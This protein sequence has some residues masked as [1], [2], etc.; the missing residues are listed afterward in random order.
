MTEKT[1]KVVFDATDGIIP[2][3]NRYGLTSEEASA[4]AEGYPVYKLTGEVLFSNINVNPKSI[5][6]HNKVNTQKKKLPLNHCVSVMLSEDS[7]FKKTDKEARDLL[8]QARVQSGEYEGLEEDE[9]PKYKTVLKTVTKKDVLD[10]KFKE[11]Q[12]GRAII[13]FAISSRPQN[14]K[15]EE[16]VVDEQ[17][18][19][20]YDRKTAL[21]FRLQDLLTGEEINPVIFKTNKSGEREYT[22]ENPQTKTKDPLKV[23]SGDLVNVY[24]RPYESQNS[25]TDEY[26]LK[27]NPLEIEIV[28]S[29]F[30]RG[31]T[32]SKPRQTKEAPSTN[33]MASV[34]GKVTQKTPKAV[35]SKVVEEPKAETKKAPKPIVNEDPDLSILDDFSDDNL[36]I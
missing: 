4:R 25:K 20:I 7:E 24:V 8:L 33:V 15:V 17:T 6:E 12:L 22:F 14:D 18:G 11:D 10:N 28:Q 9:I 1:K 5:I 16:N 27:Y 30:D 23:S 26:T 19:E 32:S 3:G 29:A 35:A 21:Y 2:T 36:D 34:F 31:L 13:N